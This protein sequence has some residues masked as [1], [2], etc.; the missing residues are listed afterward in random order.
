MNPA[1]ILFLGFAVLPSDAYIDGDYENTYCWESIVNADGSETTDSLASAGRICPSD[2]VTLVFLKSPPREVDDGETFTAS[3]LLNV[4]S[5]LSVTEEGI[6][7]TNFHACPRGV[8]CNPLWIGGSLNHIFV[9]PSDA[10]SGQLSE[11][12]HGTLT[13]SADLTFDRGEWIGIAHARFFSEVNGTRTRYDVAVGAEFTVEDT[14]E[15]METGAEIFIA[16]LTALAY[17][18]FIALIILAIHER[19]HNIM[20]H[21]GFWITLTNIFGA[22]VF[23]TTTFFWNLYMTGTTCQLATGFVTIGFTLFFGPLFTKA[24]IFY[25]LPSERHELKSS[26]PKLESRDTEIRRQ[27]QLITWGLMI[28]LAA[29]DAVILGIWLG[30]YPPEGLSELGDREYRNTCQM[31]EESRAIAI[32]V[33][34]F[35][36]AILAIATFMIW[37]AGRE[38]VE[39]TSLYRYRRAITVVAGCGVLTIIIET[40]FGKDPILSYL[41]RSLSILAATVFGTAWLWQAYLERRRMLK[42]AGKHKLDDEIGSTTDV[43]EASLVYNDPSIKAFKELFVSPII[44]GY[45]YQQCKETF[46][47][48]SIE[49]CNAVFKHKMNPTLEFAEKIIKKYVLP[50]ADQAINISSSLRS[51]VIDNFDKIK[52]AQQDATMTEKKEESKDNTHYS[53]RDGLRVL[54]DASFKEV[55]RLVYLNNWRAFRDSDYGL[56]AARWLDW[57]EY[58]DDYTETEQSWVAEHLNLQTEHYAKMA[59]E[60]TLGRPRSSTIPG[61]VTRH[62]RTRSK[63]INI[64]PPATR[65]DLRTPSQFTQPSSSQYTQRSS[66]RYTPQ[67]Q[68]S[69]QLSASLVQ[70]STQ[71]TRRKMPSGSSARM[72]R[73]IYTS[74]APQVE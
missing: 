40:A 62:R 43:S 34:T 53:Q 48:E 24:I 73:L 42:I 16:S 33:I 18:D 5:K 41:V 9:T 68:P 35:K 65:R 4:T 59:Q 70:T 13:W 2:K 60:S 51:R 47:T 66:S 58:M 10:Q 69:A 31:S 57:L 26:D 52:R 46:D 20:R 61:Q 11:Q 15:Y 14:Q 54:F 63:S 50:D 3:W 32:T 29:I 56:A 12:T 27:K 17:V 25:C 45:L 28:A 55:R 21:N 36:A 38:G 1:L 6:F 7:H 64:T 39:K 30:S 37:L 72:G 74:S 67:S 44:R 22:A 19:K 71:A 23:A 8:V 49:F